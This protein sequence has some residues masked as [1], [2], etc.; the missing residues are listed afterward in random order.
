MTVQAIPIH[1]SLAEGEF[2]QAIPLPPGWYLFI[3]QGMQAS[4]IRELL[5]RAGSFGQWKDHGV[6]GP[7]V[8]LQEGQDLDV[9]PET[10]A[11]VLYETLRK[12]FE[13]P[14]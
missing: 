1:I 5:H 8:C 12:R 2:L 14:A 6:N 9:L 7:I 4:R 3:A 13:V 11:R 10:E